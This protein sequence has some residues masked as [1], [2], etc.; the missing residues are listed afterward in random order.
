MTLK[1]SFAHSATS[2]SCITIVTNASV[3][4]LSTG[5][6]A[7]AAQHTWHSD[8]YIE[9]F[10]SGGLAISSDAETNAIRGALNALSDSFDSISNIDEI[11]IYSDSTYVLHHMLDLSIHLAYS[12]SGWRRTPTTESS[13]TMSQ[14]ARTMCSNLTMQYITLPPLLKLRLEGLQRGSLLSPQ[15]RSQTP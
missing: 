6:Q 10:R 7:V 5:Y 9:N 4:L 2:D 14:I 8:H 15:S 3:P 11:H 12:P 13:Y 1:Q